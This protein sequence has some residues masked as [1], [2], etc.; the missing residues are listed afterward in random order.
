MAFR[1]KTASMLALNPDLLI[2]PEC[3]C[4]E[5]LKFPSPASQPRYKIW[6]GDNPT[7]GIGIF[8]Y[9][10]LEI[11]LH[12]LYNPAFRYVV[13][14]KVNG[15][16]RF[17]LLAIWAMNDENDQ[18]RRYIGQIWL[19]VNRYESLLGDSIL[20]VGDF[21]WNKIWDSSPD[22]YGNLTQ[23]VEFLQSKGIVSLY[24]AFFQEA[25]GQES[26][27]TLYMHRKASRPYHIDYCF[28]SMDFV[29]QLHSVEVGSYEDWRVLSDHMPVVATFQI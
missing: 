16:K 26:R 10:D 18:A 27:P 19:A 15:D 29:N 11:T 28:A 13:P 17:N 12:E 24:H 22:L 5:R 6:I 7:K 1:K 25:F 2:I 14:I 23:T 9:S 3:E 20:I 4:L 8:S 21:N